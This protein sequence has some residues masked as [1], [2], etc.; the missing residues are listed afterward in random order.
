MNRL[1][2]EDRHLHYWVWPWK[3]NSVIIIVSLLF[4]VR[5]LDNLLYEL[6]IWFSKFK[7]FS[8]TKTSQNMASCNM[9]KYKNIHWSNHWF[10]CHCSLWYLKSN[11]LQVYLW[12]WTIVSRISRPFSCPCIYTTHLNSQQLLFNHQCWCDS[13]WYYDHLS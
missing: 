7:I 11:Q 6:Q 13:W 5:K 10:I 4:I 2:T 1:F 8:T 9:Y 3:H 12:S